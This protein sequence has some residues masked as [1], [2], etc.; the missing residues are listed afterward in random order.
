[1]QDHVDNSVLLLLEI[2]LHEFGTCLE[3]FGLPTPNKSAI[4]GDQPHAIQEEMFDV[5]EQEERTKQ[6]LETLNCEQ[7]LAYQM[8][9]KAITDGNE[10]KR[11]FFID[12]PGGHGK[13]FLIETVLST[14]CSV[15]QVALAVA[16][17]GI[18]AELLEG[19]RTVHSRFKIPIPISD[20]SMCSI[21]LQSAHAK[22]M[23]QTALI[24]WD[25]V[26]MS[27]KQHIECVDRSL[28]DILKV[29]KPFG[30][31][32]VVFGGDPRQILPVVRHGDRPRIVQSCVKCSHLWKYVHHIHLTQN[33][34]V[35]PQEVEFSKYL[36]TI[37]EGTAEVFPTIGD[38]VIKIPGDF[39]VKTLPELVE[40]V[41]PQLHD[42]YADKYY[43]AHRAILTPKNEHVDKLNAHIMSLFPGMS[44]TYRSADTIEEE[45]LLQTYPTEFL[46]SLSLSGLPPHE[47]E[48]KIGSPIMLLRNLR[49]GPGNGLRNGTRMIV[50]HLGHRVIEAEIASGVNKGK[51][52][53]IPRITLI[54]SETQFPFTLKR[55]QF[56]IRP[57]FAMTMNKA[58][59]QTLDFVGVYLPEDVFSHGQLYVAL[60]RV[61]NSSSLAVLT[62][63]M[64]GYTKNIV[65]REVL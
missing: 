34:R 20:E 38:E 40:K 28:R 2:D 41:F 6:N 3:N 24:C 16:S 44:F 59:G 39:L 48:L 61:R 27:N 15:G 57:C 26:L 62:N 19:G 10:P 46:N 60:S 52:V 8:I 50:I 23:R 55:R 18:A 32:T 53:L 63:N 33:M 47:M 45:N 37:G 42:G 43:V 25:E 54:P 5:M 1:M 12:A 31:I 7:T 65:Y 35:N 58:Q 17:S 51:C 22:L 11:L 13:T 9:L 21:S 29:N 49:A 36:L 4:I 56:P 14:V 64:D 30:G